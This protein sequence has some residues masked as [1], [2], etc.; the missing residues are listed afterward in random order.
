MKRTWVWPSYKL[1]K[2]ADLDL[3]NFLIEAGFEVA[4]KCWTRLCIVVEPA[5]ESGDPNED[6]E[7]HKTACQDGC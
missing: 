7:A 4:D 2:R 5:V 3:F 6:R 1:F